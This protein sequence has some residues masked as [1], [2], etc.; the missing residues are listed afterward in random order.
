MALR[1]ELRPWLPDAE[2]RTGD[3]TPSLTMDSRG[4]WLE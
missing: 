2:S 4:A 1:A 3:F